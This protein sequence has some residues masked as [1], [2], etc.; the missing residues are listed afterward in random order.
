M[1]A[2]P[3]EQLLTPVEVSS[4]L[5]IDMSTLSRMRSSGTGPTFILLSPRLPRYRSADIQ[6][7]LESSERRS[8]GRR[9]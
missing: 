1:T 6:N 7:W 2:L 4:L 9:S 3:P 8:G 5:H